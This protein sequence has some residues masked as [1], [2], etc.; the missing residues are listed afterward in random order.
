V[1]DA[2][3][4]IAN[5]ASAPLFEEQ[6]LSK[7]TS[8]RGI[9]AEGLARL[10]D[11]ARLANLQSTLKSE[12]GEGVLLALAFANTMLANASIN[13]ISEAVTRTRLRDQARNY[14]VEIAPGRTGL[15]IQQVLDPD[16]RI[17]LAA[18]DALGLSADASALALVGSLAADPD[19]LVARA[20]AHAVERL[21]TPR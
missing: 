14:L 21:T 15:F 3:A 19:P 6:L 5:P 11:A 2:L 4:H 18:V 8:V 17:R 7:T 10:G 13:P 16:A 20:A 12:R 1:L 9:A